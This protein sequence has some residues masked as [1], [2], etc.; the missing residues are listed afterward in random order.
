MSQQP[1]ISLTHNFNG[2][3]ISFLYCINRKADKEPVRL[4]QSESQKYTVQFRKCMMKPSNPP[5]SNGSSIGHF[6]ALNRRR[7]MYS[8]AALP[9]VWLTTLFICMLFHIQFEAL[10]CRLIYISTYKFYLQ[11]HGSRVLT[12]LRMQQA[13]GH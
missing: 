9:F 7:Y 2:S 6:C 1:Q 8:I 3:Y 13:Q 4:T 10:F 5:M 12:Y 11:M